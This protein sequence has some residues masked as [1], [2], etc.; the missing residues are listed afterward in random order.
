MSKHIALNLEIEGIGYD[1][2][3][4]HVISINGKQIAHRPYD[5]M[6]TDYLEEEVI[7]ALGSLI[8]M[9]MGLVQHSTFVCDDFDY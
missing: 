2:L 8:R 7:E 4:G 9:E 1:D 5:G 6:Q 3:G